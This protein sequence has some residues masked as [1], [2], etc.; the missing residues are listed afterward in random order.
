MAW[1]G[2]IDLPFISAMIKK[3]ARPPFTG[4]A[5]FRKPHERFTPWPIG[6]EPGHGGIPCGDGIGSLLEAQRAA[7]HGSTRLPE[8]V[9]R[10]S[11]GKAKR[12]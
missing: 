10:F 6:P 12:G 4:G 5:L 1:P 8:C 11:A 7:T 3:P 2:R 9:D